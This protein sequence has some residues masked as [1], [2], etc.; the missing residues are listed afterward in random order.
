MQLN[1]DILQASSF[2]YACNG[3]SGVLKHDPIAKP[4]F[5]LSTTLEGLEDICRGILSTR[6]W[7]DYARDASL[8]RRR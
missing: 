5:G 6:S 2:Q 8:G 1:V 3:V 4:G 7:L